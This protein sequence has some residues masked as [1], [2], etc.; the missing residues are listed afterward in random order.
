MHEKLYYWFY[1]EH[2]IFY[3]LIRFYLRRRFKLSKMFS[4]T[5]QAIS[6]L[7]LELSHINTL[8]CSML[9]S[10]VLVS[11]FIASY[12]LRLKVLS[13]WLW[14]IRK[15]WW[16]KFKGQACKGN[17]LD[18][19]HHRVNSKPKFDN[20]SKINVLNLAVM[21]GDYS[22]TYYSCPERVGCVLQFLSS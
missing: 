9:A 20:T 22:T 11:S 15:R 5:Y 17:K 2:W 14:F 10:R 8:S 1:P 12:S 3:R 4:Y 19:D 7:Y 18:N 6:L 16:N 13:M 21:C